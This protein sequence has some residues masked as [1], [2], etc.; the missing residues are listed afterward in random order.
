MS[1]KSKNYEGRKIVLLLGAGSTRSEGIRGNLPPLDNNFF[2]ESRRTN[3]EEVES[4]REYFGD[5]YNLDICDN[6]RGYDSLEYVMVRLFADSNDTSIK[7]IAYKNFLNL[8]KLFNRRLADTTN[9]IK[10]HPKSNLFRIIVS[11]LYEGADTERYFNH[12]I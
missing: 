5:N 3:K 9:E 2:T 1:K 4:I 12:Y 8:I 7:Q 6:D 11:F 10:P